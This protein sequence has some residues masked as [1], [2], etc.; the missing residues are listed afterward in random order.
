MV[1]Q[2]GAAVTAVAQTR[3]EIKLQARSKSYQARVQDSL[4]SMRSV[5]AGF[6]SLFAA[7]TGMGLEKK[8][9]TWSPAG[10]QHHHCSC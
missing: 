8:F 1:G 2:L 4:K 7:V 10:H 5:I 6:V 9:N 3:R